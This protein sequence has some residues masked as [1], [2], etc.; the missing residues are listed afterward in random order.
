MIIPRGKYDLHV[1]TSFCDGKNTAEEMAEAALAAG[2]DTLGF[3]GHSYTSFDGGYCM[4]PEAT[5]LYRAEALRLR[6]K[7]KGRLNIL[8]GVEQDIF[9]D[10]PATGFDYVI[11][12]VHYFKIDGRFFPVDKSAAV[13][14]AVANEYFGGDMIGLAC[15]YFEEASRAVEATGADIVGH[16]DL[17]TKFNE[18]G[19]LFDESDPRYVDAWQRAA[20]RLLDSGA[21]FEIN[22]GAITRGY[23]T[24]P[25]PSAAI[26]AFLREHGAKFVFSSDSHRKDSLL[27]GWDG[28]FGEFEYRPLR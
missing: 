25:Y 18:G 20:L 26:R 11:G 16:F 10:Y 19:A 2:I 5:E 13:Q 12:S 28:L 17:I 4:S 9:A 7:Y 6:E 8:L 1:H 27:Y 22:T 15:L 14:R 21:L 24:S 23:R 3:S